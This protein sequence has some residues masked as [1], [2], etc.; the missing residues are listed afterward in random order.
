MAK[1]KTKPPKVTVWTP[2]RLAQL[3]EYFASTGLDPYGVTE[4]GTLDRRFAAPDG[5]ARV[6]TGAP[7]DPPSYFS[8]E[9]RVCP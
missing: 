2:E 1:K 4:G 5:F 9:V 3:N 7:G 8:R 6:T